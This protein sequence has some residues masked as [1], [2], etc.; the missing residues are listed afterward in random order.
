VQLL[1]VKARGVASGTGAAQRLQ[2]PGTPQR[3]PSADVLAGDPEG[4]GDFCLGVAGGKQRPGLHAD[5]FEG[6]AVA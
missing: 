3:V 2:P 1:V 4:A 6:L 5:A